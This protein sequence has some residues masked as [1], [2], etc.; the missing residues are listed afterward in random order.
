MDFLKRMVNF[1][2][3]SL[4]GKYSIEFAYLEKIDETKNL[5]FDVQQT[6][7][8]LLSETENLNILEVNEDAEQF[9]KWDSMEM[10]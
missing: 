6:E 9:L 7:I 3:K 2:Y 10:L 1:D 8:P 4:P 5:T